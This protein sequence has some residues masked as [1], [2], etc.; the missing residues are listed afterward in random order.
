MLAATPSI[1]IIGGGISGLSCALR[2]RQLGFS[3]VVVYDTGARG[4]G[5]RASSRCLPWPTSEKDYGKAKTP[6]PTVVVDHAAQFFLAEHPDFKDAVAQWHADGVVKPWE[7]KLGRVSWAPQERN[8]SGGGGGGGGPLFEPFSDDKTRWIGTQSGGGIGGIATN[9]ASKL[10]VDSVVTDCWV[11]PGNG[12]RRL[13]DGK[14][15]V[16]VGPKKENRHDCLVIAHNGKCAHRLTSGTPAVGLNKLLQVKFNDRPSPSAMTLNA[17]YSLVVELEFQTPPKSTGGGGGGASS[18]GNS[19]HASADAAASTAGVKTSS[20]DKHGSSTAAETTAAVARISVGD[21]VKL[22]EQPHA[23]DDGLRGIVAEVGADGCTV[24]LMNEG[25]RARYF[26]MGQLAVVT[27]SSGRPPPRTEERAAEA[28]LAAAGWAHTATDG[29]VVAEGPQ[30]GGFGFDGAFVVGSNVLQWAASNTNKYGEGKSGGS[31]L[32][33]E[34][35]TLMSTASFAKTWKVPQEA[36][37]GTEAEQA[38]TKVMLDEA[39]KLFTRPADNKDTAAAATAA[40]TIPFRVV[41][42]KLQLWG[43]GVPLNTWHASDGSPFAFEGPHSIGAV[44]DWLCPSNPSIEG[45]FVSGRA[46]ANHLA[47]SSSSSSE[48]GGRPKSAGMSG[49]FVN[50]G[51]AGL[52]AVGE[53][54]QPLP[55]SPRPQPPNKTPALSRSAPATP[56]SN[57]R[58]TGN[59]G[60]APPTGAYK[61]K[62]T[63]AAAAVAGMPRDKERNPR[64]RAGELPTARPQSQRP[65]DWTCAACKAHVFASKKACYRCQAPKPLL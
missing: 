5:G 10:P 3:S 25:N 9:M 17:V 61:G 26:E 20:D 21:V 40:R 60:G 64:R 65:G 33:R 22:K 42:S 57:S 16:K 15:S 32:R 13:S 45:A 43:A 62:E 38:V 35:W 55:P 14:W 48:S 28:A 58:V 63:A 39:S 59:G 12:I 44:G 8:G 34:V 2:L 30:S 11:S 36:L 24:R 27:G 29:G 41:H 23:T 18:G 1:G 50:A 31:T 4:V 7:G 53:K 46:L 52:G 54:Q 51:A 56:S 49:K 19:D 6:S 37:E 47:S